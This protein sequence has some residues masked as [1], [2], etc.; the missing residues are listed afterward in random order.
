[1]RTVG[2]IVPEA[3][4]VKADEAKDVKADEVEGKSTKKAK[5]ANDMYVTYDY[6][7]NY[8]FN[9]T[10]VKENEFP[11]Y[12]LKAR[13][14]IKEHTLNRSDNF[15]Q[16][17]LKACACELIDLFYK[18]DNDEKYTTGTAAGISSEKVGEYSVSYNGPSA[19]DLKTI[20]SKEVRSIIN[21][22][23]GPYGL[24]FRG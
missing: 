23:L 12:E 15:D 2:L 7:L 6:Y 3:K 16:E 19:Q 5:Q 13:S 4:D 1:M 9:N 20:K 17:E 18:Y 24:L 11:Y 14:A 8:C 22:Y 21:K 10:L